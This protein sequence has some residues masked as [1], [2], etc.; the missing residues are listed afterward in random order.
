MRLV[1]YTL[2]CHKREA[3]L[4]ATLPSVI[5]AANAAP[6][7]EIVIVDYGHPGTLVK[8]VWEHLTYCDEGVA[9]RSIRVEREHFHMAHARNVG[10]REARGEYVVAFLADQ[11]ISETFFGAV[12]R[13]LAEPKRLLKWQETFAARRTDWL[14]LGGIDQR[15]EFYGPEG[16]ELTDRFERAG[17]TVAPF[18]GCDISQIRTSNVEKVRNYRLPMTKMEMHL[19]GMEVWKDNQAR[20]VTVANQGVEWGAR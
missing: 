1:S 8:L 10:I 14:A 18:E 20:G 12:R 9:L 5:V 4:R 19:L 3:D 16:K 2:P 13:G 15:F 17:F 6:P 7:V 11:I